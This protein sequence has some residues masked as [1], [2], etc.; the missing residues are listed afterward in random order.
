M[1]PASGDS[2]SWTKPGDDKFVSIQL[3]SPASGDSNYLHQPRLRRN[4]VSIQ[5][6]SPA[7]GDS[8]P[9][10]I[11][12]VSKRMAVSIQL[13]SPASGDQ[14]KG[15]KEGKAKESCFHS[16]N[17]PSEWGPLNFK[18]LPSKVSR[19]SFQRSGKK[20]L[21]PPTHSRKKPPKPLHSKGTKFATKKST[22]QP[23]YLTFGKTK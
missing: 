13:M 6:M 2:I 23:F 10:W 4:L 3:M 16:I 19:G 21:K 8:C 5:L 9:A 17:V 14:F 11:V 22:L 12:F 18:P 15:I 1:S 7:S 20:V